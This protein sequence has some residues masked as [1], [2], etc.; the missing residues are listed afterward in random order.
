MR[1]YGSVM[2]IVTVLPLNIF[3]TEVTM[4]KVPALKPD[5]CANDA[6]IDVVTI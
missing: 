2:G 6:A 3:Q 5:K 1:K 4:Y